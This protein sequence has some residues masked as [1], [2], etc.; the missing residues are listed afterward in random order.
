MNAKTM[1]ELADKLRIRADQIDNRLG[2]IPGRSA[3][4]IAIELREASLALCLAARLASERLTAG[5]GE[6]EK[7]SIAADEVVARI[8]EW[9]D[10]TSPD[11]FPEALLITSSELHSELMRFAENIL[12][13]STPTAPVVGDV[14][15]GMQK[16]MEIVG[17]MRQSEAGLF[18]AKHS[19]KRG[20]DRS[21]AL[22]D[23]YQAIRTLLPPA[24]EGK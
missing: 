5:T 12:A 8:N 7:I 18:D 17:E 20:E 1:L 22:Y 9:D 11:D 4:D 13:I 21:N 24:Q 15:E 3:D 6:R 10:R 2:P 19:G 14:R 23:A 16:A